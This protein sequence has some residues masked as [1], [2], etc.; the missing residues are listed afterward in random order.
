MVAAEKLITFD[1]QIK[2]IGHIKSSKIIAICGQA[3]VG[4]STFINNFFEK[5]IAKTSDEQETCT[6]DIDFYTSS[7]QYSSLQSIKDENQKTNNAI[8]FL[9][10]EGDD[11]GDLTKNLKI[12]RFT[13]SISQVF[14]YYARDKI[15]VH[16]LETIRYIKKYSG[17]I[18]ILF[19]RTQLK[20]KKS[21]IFDHT[22]TFADSREF[23]KSYVS[24]E[25]KK[26]INDVPIRDSEIIMQTLRENI[27]LQ[28]R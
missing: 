24:A 19:V 10:V 26:I 20:H 11:L 6:K 2:I 25:F 23:L 4:K 17:A 3:R 13:A 7:I 1:Q 22:F 28:I 15:S 16:S 27:N 18:M 21:E 12:A 14:I 9:D 5:K 8:T